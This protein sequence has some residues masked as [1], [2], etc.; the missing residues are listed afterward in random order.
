VATPENDSGSAAT[1]NDIVPNASN[2]AVDA[3]KAYL[4]ILFMSYLL[5]VELTCCYTS[6]AA[7][8]LFSNT[9]FI[10]GLRIFINCLS[11]LVIPN[12]RRKSL[13]LLIVQYIR[14]IT[15][16]GDNLTLP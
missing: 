3:V 11:A 12:I 15:Y 8:S 1:R 14:R 4:L 7:S 6:P 5:N 16:V 10:E 2:N 9:Y 13:I